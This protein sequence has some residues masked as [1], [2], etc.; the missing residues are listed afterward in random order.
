MEEILLNAIII[1]DETKAQRILQTLLKEHC[2]GVEVLAVASDVVEG[3]KEI[4]AKK[5]DLVFLD[6]ELPGYSGFELLD[7]FQKPEFGIIFTTAYSEF[8]IRAF[9]LS[10]IDYLLKPLQISKLQTAV[11]KAKK[12]KG[13]QIMEKLFALKN[14]LQEEKS[15][16]IA[17]PVA[18][19]YLFAEE[20]E[21]LYFEADNSY[22]TIFLTNGNKVLVSRGL[23]D[24]VELIQ[25][26]N[27]YKPHRSYYIN[28]NQIRQYSKQDGGQIVMKNN[29]TIFVARD[30][31]Q[32]F[33]QLLSARGMV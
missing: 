20:D 31:K 9:E 26:K 10:A 4:V 30:R 21:I 17:L 1:E 6:I 27:F 11:E 19:G 14:N 16:K 2:K 23:K 12:E 13:R 18:D 22:T 8:A 29:D 15:K 28:L 7:F 32:E 33:L 24:F 5:P 3:V 25:S